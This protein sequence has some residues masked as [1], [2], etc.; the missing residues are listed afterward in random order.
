MYFALLGFFCLFVFTY[1]LYQTFY[2]KNK[3]TGQ[4]GLAPT[5]DFVPGLSPW[6]IDG[7]FFLMSLHI[8]SLSVCLCVQISHLY[9]TPVILD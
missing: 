1:W 8:S 9:K 3:Q 4:L 6:L 7:C 2:S 5:L